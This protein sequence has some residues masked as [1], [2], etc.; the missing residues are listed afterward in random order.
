MQHIVMLYAR[1]DRSLPSRAVFQTTSYALH[2]HARFFCSSCMAH[3]ENRT[4]CRDH[5]GLYLTPQHTHRTP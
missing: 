1:A 5:W 3:D 2:T 4:C